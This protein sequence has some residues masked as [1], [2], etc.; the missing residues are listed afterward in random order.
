MEKNVLASDQG[1]ACLLCHKAIALK[2][3]LKRHFEMMHWASNVSFECPV[4]KK[5]FPH[6]YAFRRHLSGLHPQ[7]K[8]IDIDRCSVDQEQS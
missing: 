5:M 1:Y 2:R 6:K 4:C 8:G 3:N 7:F